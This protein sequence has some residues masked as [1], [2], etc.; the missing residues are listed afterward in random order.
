[1]FSDIEK[2]YK[3]GL[4]EKRFF[5]FY[6]PRVFLVVILALCLDFLLNINR[7]IVY[8][9]LVAVLL[10]LILFF[11]ARDFYRANKNLAAVRQNKGAVAKMR[12]YFDADDIV[13]INNLVLDLARHDIRTKRDLELTLDYFQTRLPA[14][15]RPNLFEWVLT[16]LITFSSIVVVTYD[17]TIGAISVQ[18]LISTVGSTLVVAL[19]ILTP[20]ILAKI[21]STSISSSRNK[22]DTILVEDLAYIYI[23]FE[24]Y[25]KT[26]EHRPRAQGE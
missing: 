12:A 7:W 9:L 16:A 15:T 2:E 21:I 6:W 1:M 18:K 4:Q 13:R 26:L 23:H 3:K 25:Q 19:I 5:A 24:D 14:N 20:L 22:V 11:F 17:D 10:L 8:G